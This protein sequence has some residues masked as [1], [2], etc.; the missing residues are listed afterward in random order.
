MPRG[1][2]AVH[3]YRTN[4]LQVL[5]KK[6]LSLLFCKRPIENLVWHRTKFLTE[7]YT[8]KSLARKAYLDKLKENAMDEEDEDAMATF[9]ADPAN[10]KLKDEA[11]ISESL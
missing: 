10:Q 2:Y 6:S 4:L 8:K 9:L 1:A 11:T 3:P 7:E 5:P